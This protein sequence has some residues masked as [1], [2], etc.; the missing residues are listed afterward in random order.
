MLNNGIF[1]VYIEEEKSK[2]KTL[3][4]GL[5]QGFVLA[6][7]FFNIYT[8]DLPATSARKFIYADDLALVCQSKDFKD[9]ENTLTD[10]LDILHKYDKQ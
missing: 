8:K 6:H 9:L 2:I 10:D 3:N 1:T 7:L 5:P 4:N